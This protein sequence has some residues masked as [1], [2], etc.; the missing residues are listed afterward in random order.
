MSSLFFT[1]ITHFLCQGSGS[2]P[3][4]HAISR[5][6]G[7]KPIRSVLFPPPTAVPDFDL[8]PIIGM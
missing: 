7:G 4:Q 6:D 1:I 3:P 5:Q 8:V 2:A